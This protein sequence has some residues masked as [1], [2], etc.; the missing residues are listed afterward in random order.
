M[1]PIEIIGDVHVVG[2]QSAPVTEKFSQISLWWH[3]TGSF[4]VVV[5]CMI[6]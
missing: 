3:C 6:L 2:E 5:L 1:G 4:V